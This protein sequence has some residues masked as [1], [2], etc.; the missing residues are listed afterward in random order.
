MASNSLRSLRK[1]PAPVLSEAQ[2]AW[3]LAPLMQHG[4]LLGA[5]KTD[6]GRDQ[7]LVSA[8]TKQNP[9]A[10]QFAH[11]DLRSSRDFVVQL[12]LQ[13]MQREPQTTGPKRGRKPQRWSRAEK[14]QM[15]RFVSKKL[16]SDLTFMMELV[17]TEGLALAFAAADLRQNRDLVM[18]AAKNNP[19]SLQ[20]AAAALKNKVDFIAGLVPHQ[21]CVM[22]HVSKKLWGNEALVTLALQRDGTLLELAPSHFR[23]NKNMVLLAV[24]ETP[25][26][27]LYAAEV[28]RNDAEIIAKAKESDALLADSFLKTNKQA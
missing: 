27:L 12:F 21:P 16:K 24:A 13:L 6:Y 17:Q 22:R 23:S 26:A 7:A 11:A 19:D 28:L 10:F 14:V 8:A 25:L 15:L 4:M 3:V 5:L 1:T 2:R 20:F 9:L 18:A